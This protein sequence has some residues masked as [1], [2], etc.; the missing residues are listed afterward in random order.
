M[1]VS[2]LKIYFEYNMNLSAVARNPQI[3]VLNTEAQPMLCDLPPIRVFFIHLTNNQEQPTHASTANYLELQERI[4]YCR[5]T[6]SA[7]LSIKKCASLQWRF[8]T[9]VVTG[10]VPRPSF[11]LCH[12]TRT[13]PLSPCQSQENVPGT[14]ARLLVRGL[15]RTGIRWNLKRA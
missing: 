7:S 1:Y 15:V 11:S 14:P 4:D 2:W 3:F 10:A 8:M 12:S 13:T 6:G 5:D 9:F